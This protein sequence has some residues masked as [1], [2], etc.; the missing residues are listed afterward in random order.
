[1]ADG[2]IHKDMVWFI[3]GQ[4]EREYCIH[5]AGTFS[6]PLS[7]AGQ[8]VLVP[9]L[10]ETEMIFNSARLKCSRSPVLDQPVDKITL[11]AA[12]HLVIDGAFGKRWVC[13]KT[14]ISV[15][16]ASSDERNLPSYTGPWN[17]MLW[18]RAISRMQ[19]LFNFGEG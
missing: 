15:S 18:Y 6:A 5:C 19:P 2:T 12:P 10:P 9:F 4:L 17:F 14:R 1:M 13:I 11:E 7:R 3:T 8:D 16:P